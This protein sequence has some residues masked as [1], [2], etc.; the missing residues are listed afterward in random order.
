ML[1]KGSLSTLFSQK[2]SQKPLR[3]VIDTCPVIGTRPIIGTLV[4]TENGQRLIALFKDELDMNYNSDPSISTIQHR[5]A[6]DAR[7]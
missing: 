7:A 5:T 1:L 6:I 4:A 2:C 3:S